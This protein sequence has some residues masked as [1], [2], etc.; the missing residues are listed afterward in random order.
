M[1]EKRATLFK[2]L[3]Q[4]LV[5]RYAL[6]KKKSIDKNAVL[7]GKIIVSR[8]FRIPGS[9]F[10]FDPN[11]V[12]V[13]SRGSLFC[14]FL[15]FFWRRTSLT[16]D[17]TWHVYSNE[18][19]SSKGFF[20]S[21]IKEGICQFPHTPRLPLEWQ[22]K[23]RASLTP[24]HWATVAHRHFSVATGWPRF[25]GYGV[26]SA[27]LPGQRWQKRRKKKKRDMSM[28]ALLN[29]QQVV[30]LITTNKGKEDSGT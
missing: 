13:C 30:H 29:L 19:C 18:V 20:I 12:Q 7:Q 2:S 8:Q 9:S 17:S 14:L 27:F 10:M 4:G 22:I 23:R 11:R 1:K 5:C 21:G 26:P 6:K 24:L 16:G 15:R 25:Y 3:G 28:W